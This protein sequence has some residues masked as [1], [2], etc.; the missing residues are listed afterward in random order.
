MVR[1]RIVQVVTLVLAILVGQLG[2]PAV[3][4]AAKVS[5]RLNSASLKVESLANDGK[6]DAAIDLA[7]RLVA[8]A[9]KTLAKTDPRRIV[10]QSQLA[11]MYARSRNSELSLNAAKAAVSELSGVVASSDVDL[12]ASLSKLAEIFDKAGNF[13]QAE[14]LLT[15]AIAE[16]EDRQGPDSIGI[17]PLQHQ[18][19]DIYTRH[20]RT[21]EAAQ[22]KEKL[23]AV[24]ASRAAVVL[25]QESSP[26]KSQEDRTTDTESGASGAA[27]PESTPA[28]PAKSKAEPKPDVAS[29]RSHKKGGSKQRSLTAGQP[30]SA[31]VAPP[32]AATVAPAYHVVPVF[33][34]TNRKVSGGLSAVAFS[35]AESDALTLGVAMVTVPL[36]HQVPQVERPWSLRVPG[37][38]VEITFEAQD[39]TK[40]FTISSIENLPQEQ[41]IARA[42][43]QL[44][45]SQTYKGQA[46]VFVHGFYN[47]F[48]DA[49]YRTAQI[50]Y[51]L[52]FDGAAFMF[53]W[54]SAGTIDAYWTDRPKAERAGDK[55]REFLTLVAK[56]SGATR[57][58]VIAHSMGNLPLLEALDETAAGDQPPLTSAIDEIV[59]AAPDV[60]R[61]EFTK[62][63]QHMSHVRGG[64]TLY[65]ASNDLALEASR[66]LNHEPRAGDT[67]YGGPL[68]LPRIDTIDAT[69]ASTQVFRLNHY[70]VAESSPIMCD[71]EHLLRSGARPPNNRSK[72]LTSVK[73]D[74]G[75]YYAYRP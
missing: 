26:E 6:L 56:E 21:V 72:M 45:A 37:T 1:S 48:D 10:Y 27:Q 53:S 5:D 7:K 64:I 52:Q 57:I 22:L 15:R 11:D 35:S 69:R 66:T 23:G 58:S 67:S 71:L 43:S 18:L 32:S 9:D 65:A 75:T 46:M 59:L 34:G 33:Y 55:L 12:T 24:E 31:P 2:N 42:K 44:A 25:P 62:L 60:G 14:G 29:P 4:F 39:P 63:A 28:P 19:A 20:G 16:L 47:K 61:E 38:D 51:D 70:Y 49:I 74:A 36:T 50:A 68:L 17:V 3:T 8:S 40:H 73:A 30:N 41:F 54:P 13:E